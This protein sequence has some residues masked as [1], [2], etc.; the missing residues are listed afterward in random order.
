MRP[1]HRFKAS[2]Q[3]DGLSLEMEVEEGDRPTAPVGEDAGNKYSML[4]D[5]KKKV[6]E[7]QKLAS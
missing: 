3:A 4:M 6:Q 5:R 2:V 7:A 1:L